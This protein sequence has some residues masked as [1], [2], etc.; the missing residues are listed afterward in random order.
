MSE[1]TT[2]QIRDMIE[3]NGGP[4]ELVLD[5]SEFGFA[6]EKASNPVCWCLQT[7]LVAE[8]AL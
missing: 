6:G 8:T 5:S 1:Y 3:A 2:H 4:Q 7:N